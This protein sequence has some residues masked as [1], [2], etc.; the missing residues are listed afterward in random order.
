M[1]KKKLGI[2]IYIFHNLLAVLYCTI[3]VTKKDGCASG[4]K[5]IEEGSINWPWGL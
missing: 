5:I 3:G 2:I 4:F 1:P